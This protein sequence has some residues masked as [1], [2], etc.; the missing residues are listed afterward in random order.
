ME[1]LGTIL[2]NGGGRSASAAELQDD[3]YCLLKLQESPTIGNVVD[4][5]SGWWEGGFRILNF[6]LGEGDA[7]RGKANIEHRTSNIEHRTSNIQRRT[8]ENQERK[9]GRSGCYFR[10]FC[11]TLGVRC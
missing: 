5:A 2:K 11:S 10:L 6:E 3:Q 9:M 1:L 8:E 7:A 4:V